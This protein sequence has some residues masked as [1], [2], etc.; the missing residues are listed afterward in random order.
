MASPILL[1]REDRIRE[2]IAVLGLKLE[3]SHIADP[4]L[5]PRTPFYIEELYNRRKRKG[6]TRREAA[7]LIQNPDMFGSMMVHLDDA[8]AM[9]CGLTR[10]YPDA[11]RPA[12]QVIPMQKGIGKVAGMYIVVTPRGKLFFLADCTVNIDLSSPW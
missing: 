8:A 12:L 4:R 9:I 6:V 7:E 1:G 11:L 2:R 10:H 3:G 5:S